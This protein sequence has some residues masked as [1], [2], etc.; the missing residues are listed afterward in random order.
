MRQS[1]KEL[2]VPISVVKELNEMHYRHLQEITDKLGDHLVKVA[3]VYE[4]ALNP[5]LLAPPPM[6]K[7]WISEYEEDEAFDIKQA[8]E[9]AL[10]ELGLEDQFNEVESNL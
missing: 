8:E 2:M 7:A 10:R 1:S 3:E 6:E 4:R 5:P 9:R